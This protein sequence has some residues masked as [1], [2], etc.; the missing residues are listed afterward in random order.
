MTS[1][2]LDT[3]YSV[4]ASCNQRSVACGDLQR[5]TR[6]GRVQSR[7]ASALQLGSYSFSKLYIFLYSIDTRYISKAGW[8]SVNDYNI[9]VS[10]VTQGNFKLAVEQMWPSGQCVSI[11]DCSVVG[12]GYSVVP[13]MI[14]VEKAIR[15]DRARRLDDIATWL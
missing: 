8:I 15:L 9:I 12:I 7:I 13:T 11:A 2:S 5:D 14:K 6:H 10:M 3:R 1:G 4:D